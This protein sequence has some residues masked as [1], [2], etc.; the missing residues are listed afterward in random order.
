VSVPDRHRTRADRTAGERQTDT[1][2]RVRAVAAWFPAIAIAA[3]IFTLS[4]Q[5]NL[6]ITEGA[7]DLVLRKCAHMAVFGLLGAG[8]LRAL[9]FHGLRGRTALL[10]AA[11]LAI[12]YSI[13]D[14]FHQTFVTGRSG[15]PIDVAIDVV[16]IALALAVIARSPRVRARIVVPA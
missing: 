6:R 1:L 16:G 14:E 13:S 11:A 3:I 2:H 9:A 15:S 10:G 12:A 7:A 5:A 8:C 4:A